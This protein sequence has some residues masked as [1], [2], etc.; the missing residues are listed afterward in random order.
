MTLSRDVV[1]PGMLE[2]YRSF[3]ELLRGL[4]AQQWETASRCDGWR[5]GD[6]AAHVV[7]QL[8]DVVNLRL[9]GLGSPE[10]TKRQVDERRGQ[11]PGD[12]ADELGASTKVAGDLAPSFDEAAWSGPVP[13]GGSGTLGFGL[14][15]L[16]FD[17]YLHGDDVR[18]A[19]G[20]TRPSDDGTRPSVSH[21]AQVLSDQEWGPAELAFPGLEVFP[22]SGGGGRTIT[23]DAFSFILASTG[24]GQPAA[25][26]LDESVNIYR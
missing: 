22:I 26:D 23:G 10:V 1:I 2:E 8:S 3:E 15:A 17:T 14:E 5:V 19:V 11:T 9:E 24:R 21:I 7:G 20:Q 16:W 6:V 18:S 4:S 25:F 13:G 12:L